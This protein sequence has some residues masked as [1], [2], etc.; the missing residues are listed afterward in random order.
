[1]NPILSKVNA[2]I[3]EFDELE[4][5]NQATC[6]E[7]SDIDK[8]ISS[9]YHKLEGLKITH[10]SQSHKLI[11]ELKPL[12]ERRRDIKIEE[13]ILTSTCD[14][15]RDK[16]NNLKASNKTKL[17]KHESVIEECKNGKNS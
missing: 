14:T 5:L 1:M 9:W 13:I 2:F 8:Q 10:V 4:R 7:R 15:L 11:M 6:K 12:L 16:V 3:H 17:L